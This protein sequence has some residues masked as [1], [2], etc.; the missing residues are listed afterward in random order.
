MNK[1]E[2][3]T[4]LIDVMFQLSRVLKDQGSFRNDLSQLTVLQIH[5]LWFLKHHTNAQM[6][7][8]AQ[9]FNIELPSSTSL[10]NK[11]CILEL[12]ERKSDDHDRRLVRISLTKRGEQ[13][14]NEAMNKRMKKLETMLSLLDENDKKELQ[15]ILETLLSKIK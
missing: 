12:V 7:E 10:V 4:H 8:I 1:N 15:R 2:Q 11:L 3:T 6:S 13:L 14:L 9:H 5:A